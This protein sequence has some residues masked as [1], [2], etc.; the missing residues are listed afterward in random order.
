MSSTSS[1]HSMWFD[2]VSIANGI[3]FN[4]SLSLLDS[5]IDARVRL[6]V[7]VCLD[8]CVYVCAN[9]CVSMCVYTCVCV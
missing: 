6:F 3:L 5:S 2:V 8:G 1:R 9:K 7:H 4:C